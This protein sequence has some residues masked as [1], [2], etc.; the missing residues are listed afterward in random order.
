MS[1]ASSQLNSSYDNPADDNIEGVVAIAAYLGKSVRRTFYLLETRQ[2]PGFQQGRR[3]NLRKS[4]YR[5]Q[6]EKLEAAASAAKPPKR[7]T[8]T[9]RKKGRP[10]STRATNEAAAS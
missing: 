5:R 4:T 1:T 3:W 10:R 6:F 7:G 9:K 2:L 8:L